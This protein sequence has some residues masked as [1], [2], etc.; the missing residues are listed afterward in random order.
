V[1]G[2]IFEG[3]IEKLVTM[4]QILE[5]QLYIY[6]KQYKNLINCSLI[7]YLSWFYIMYKK[8]LATYILL[9]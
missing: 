6:C 5:V 3:L 4:V 2:V 8:T 9:E 7:I 1:V